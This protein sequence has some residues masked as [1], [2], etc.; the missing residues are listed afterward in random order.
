MDQKNYKNISLQAIVMLT[1]PCSEEMAKN[2]D[3]YMLDVYN[4]ESKQA[5]TAAQ[6]ESEHDACCPLEPFAHLL[7]KLFAER[8]SLESDDASVGKASASLVR[9]NTITLLCLQ[10]ISSCLPTAG[11]D[12]CT[13]ACRVL[14]HDFVKCCASC[15]RKNTTKDDTL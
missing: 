2:D 4:L 1:M 12:A 15:I 5:F 8:E 11:T 14:L 13:Y 6:C 3:N 10:E 7:Q 9:K